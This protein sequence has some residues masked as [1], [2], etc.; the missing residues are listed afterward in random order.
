MSL[1]ESLAETIGTSSIEAGKAD[2]RTLGAAMAAGKL[3]AAE[4]TAFYLDRIARLNPSLRAVITTAPSAPSAAAASDTRRAAGATLGPLDGLPV[5]IKDNVSV[6]GSPA[7]AGSPALERAGSTDAFLVVRLRAAGAVIIG[8]AN[9][10]EW[11][12]FRSTRSTSGW[13]TVGGQAVNPR[14]PGRNPSGSSSGSAVAVAAGLAP[15]AVG[16]ETDGSIVCPASAC[17]IVG[18]KPTTG[19][20]SRAGVV[21][22]SLA[23]DTAGP[24]AAC[25]ADAAALLAVLAAVDPADPASG[26]FDGPAERHGGA[27]YTEY[28]DPA[29][30]AGARLGVWRAASADAGVAIEAVLDAAVARLRRGGAD[31]RDPADLP[32]AGQIGE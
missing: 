28:L 31:V 24:M 1:T 18:I 14:G 13:S 30:L 2:V 22:V 20:V 23:Q 5:L 8:K 3:S 26:K 32:G 16:T 4:L 25:V 10:S 7:T 17:G 21:P 9:L 27:Q 15:L 6:D 19:L 12:N 29:A 11:A